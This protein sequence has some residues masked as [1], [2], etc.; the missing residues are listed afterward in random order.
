[1]LGA[2]MDDVIS[3][4]YKIDELVEKINTN[5]KKSLTKADK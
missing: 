2:G 5:I 1:M 4:P 3:K